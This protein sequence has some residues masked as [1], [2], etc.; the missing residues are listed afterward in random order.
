[1]LRDGYVIICIWLVLVQESIFSSQSCS[2]CYAVFYGSTV[3]F[4]PSILKCTWLS[5][6]IFNTSVIALLRGISPTNCSV[7]TL[8]WYSIVTSYHLAIC[9]ITAC[10][11]AW[12]NWN[13]PFF[14][15][16]DASTS[17]SSTR[18]ILP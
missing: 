9:R 18:S 15:A 14:Q 11:S 16:I 10:T 1:M 2:F 7:G 8:P 6:S 3:I 17:A 13:N 12:L 4:F 5:S